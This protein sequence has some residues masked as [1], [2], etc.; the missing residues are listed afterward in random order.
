VFEEHASGADRGRPVLARLLREIQSGETLVVVR[1]DR[2]ARSVTHLLAV[3][4]QLEAAALH[5]GAE[6]L[7]ARNCP[8]RNVNTDEIP[9]ILVRRAPRTQSGCGTMG[10]HTAE[11]FENI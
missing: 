8:V 5:F 3:I 11:G 2:L 10:L 9:A 6:G 1:L 4:E 7:S